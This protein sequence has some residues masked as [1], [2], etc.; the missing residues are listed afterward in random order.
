[1]NLVIL[2][3]G[4]A[5]GDGCYRLNDHRAEHIRTILRAREGDKV[6]VGL[7]NGSMGTAQISSLSGDEIELTCEELHPPQELPSTD[8]ICA[9][10]RPQTLKKVLIT[11]G[12]MGI[13]RL[14]L[15]R[16]NR[17]E[18]SYYQSPLIQPENQLPYLLEGLSQG[19]LTRLPQVTVHDRFKVFFEDT[20]PDLETTE[21]IQGLRLLAST[22]ALQNM[23]DFYDAAV[24]RVTIAIGPEGGWVPFEVDLM[25]QAGFLRFVLG[26]WVLRVETAVV[27]ALGQLDLL[28]MKS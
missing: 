3:E 15:I 10:P 19:K 11:C 17:V 8:L 7:L 25:Q 28:R 9:L 13:R 16:A 5:V 6:E 22:E 27:S 20:F 4:D 18:K 12:M 26:R 2:V 14:H 21:T 24:D 1:M 23:S